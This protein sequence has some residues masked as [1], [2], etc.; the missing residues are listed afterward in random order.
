[1]LLLP[2]SSTRAQFEET[3]ITPISTTSSTLQVKSSATVF[4][5]FKEEALPSLSVMKDPFILLDETA[6]IHLEYIHDPVDD[7]TSTR[8]TNDS[9]SD[10]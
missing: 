2:E 5:T 9:T 7:T 3:A 6:V 8:A 10:L 4:P 1:M